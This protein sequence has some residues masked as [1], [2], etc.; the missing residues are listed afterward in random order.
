M[1]QTI[2][3]RRSD[4]RFPVAETLWVIASVILLLALGDVVIVLVLALAAAT[5]ATTWCMRRNAGHRA[6]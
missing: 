2:L 3:R 6:A 4:V 5:M 1:R